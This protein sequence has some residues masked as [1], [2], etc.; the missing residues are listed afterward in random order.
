MLARKQ[1]QAVYI[2]GTAG[3]A[4]DKIEYAAAVKALKKVSAK[5]SIVGQVAGNGKV[6]TA[7]T[8]VASSLQARP[9]VTSF[10]ALSDES[11]LGAV[12]ALKASG[13][14]ASST[15]ITDIGGSDQAVAAFDAGSIY[16]IGKIDFEGDLKQ[17]IDWLNKAIKN[18]GTPGTIMYTPVKEFVK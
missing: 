17:N 9:K 3:A 7:Q 10:L 11:A 8:A 12:S 14:K 1:T 6:D 16:A 5:L 18:P 13:K 4:A 15:C 2:A